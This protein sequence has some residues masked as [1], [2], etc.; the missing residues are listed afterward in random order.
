MQ[1]EFSQYSIYE[2]IIVI[3]A[4][5][6]ARTSSL[7]ERYGKLAIYSLLMSKMVKMIQNGCIA[8]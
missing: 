3:Y 5:L 8:H 4:R 6:Q 2:E 1:W 7:T